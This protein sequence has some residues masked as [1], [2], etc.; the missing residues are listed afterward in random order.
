[1]AN[2]NL[3]F[4]AQFERTATNALDKQQYHNSHIEGRSGSSDSRL[5]DPRYQQTAKNV[6]T[7]AQL[8]QLRQGSHFSQNPKFVQNSQN[9]L[10]NAPPVGPWQKQT[11]HN[12]LPFLTDANSA[13]GGPGNTFYSA[14]EEENWQGN[15]A[16]HRTAKDKATVQSPVFEEEGDLFSE[17]VTA[18]FFL[19]EAPSSCPVRLFQSTALALTSACIVVTEL[20]GEARKAESRLAKGRGACGGGRQRS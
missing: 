10:R 7:K 12:Q 14:G 2:T 17:E 19:G 6:F 11:A 9:I 16:Q 5:L 8:L 20:P 4:N 13:A 18:P 15:P 3:S 1:M